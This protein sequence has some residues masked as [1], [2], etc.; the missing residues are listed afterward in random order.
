[1]RD[2]LRFCKAGGGVLCPGSG[3]MSLNRKGCNYIIEY[4]GMSSELCFLDSPFENF[5]RPK[6]AITGVVQVFIFFSTPYGFQELL[7]LLQPYPRTNLLSFHNSGNY[8]T[9][10]HYV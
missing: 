6:S 8:L 7:L 1:M 10:E 5:L 9:P 2:K 4:E 3:R